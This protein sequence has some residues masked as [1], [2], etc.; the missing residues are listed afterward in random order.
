M[1]AIPSREL[2]NDIAAVLRRVERGESLTITVSGRPV[3]RLGPLT[4]R[5]PAMPAATLLAAL[6]LVAADRGLTADLAEILGDTT[7]DVA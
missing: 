1:D 4:R 2:R 7:D 3:A 5:P 6:D